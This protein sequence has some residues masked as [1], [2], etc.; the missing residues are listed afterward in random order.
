MLNQ[1]KAAFETIQPL[2]QAAEQA[3]DRA[4]TDAATCIAE[5]L[6]AREAANLPM[7]VGTEMLDKMVLA[8]AAGVNARKHF[9]EAHALTPAVVKEIGL[10]KMF[11]DIHPCP[12][13]KPASGELTLVQ[14]TALAA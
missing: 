1:R 8:L 3:A 5:M 9:I 13:T 2:F 11:G 12:R 6:K 10:E 7:N 4:A 14:P